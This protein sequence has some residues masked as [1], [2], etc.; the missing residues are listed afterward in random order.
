M[1]RKL[2]YLFVAVA[3]VWLPIAAMADSITPSSFSGSGPTGASY[4]VNKTVTVSAGTPT[5]ALV[6]IFFLA[7]NTGSM[8]SIIGAVQ[9]GASS[10]LTSTAGLGNVAWGVGAYKDNGDDFVYQLNQ[11]ITTNQASVQAGINAWVASGGGDTPEAQLYALK[12]MATDAATG[13]RTGSTRIAVWFGDEPGHDPSGPDGT[14][15]AQAT[16]A[17]VGQGIIVEALSVGDNQLD[18]TGQ[19]TRI[20]DATG[21]TLFS[22]V[23]STGVVDAIIAAIEAAFATY[24]TVSLDTS[25]VPPEVGVTVNPGSYVGDFDRSIDRTFGFEVTFTDLEP[26]THTF[27]IYALVDG[28]RVATE[29]DSITSRGGEIPEPATMILIGFGLLGIAG[30]RKR[31][32]K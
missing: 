15:E 9:T 14:T 10:I 28:G 32:K 21:G 11:S 22:G 4:T 12:R 25:E 20:T 5:E 31:F 19:A 2:L 30:L 18:S 29:S 8:G 3:L 13:W 27:N 17:L 26:G 7:D 6:D 16:A 23:D 1:K 24:N